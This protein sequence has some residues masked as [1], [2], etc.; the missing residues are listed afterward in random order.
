M[1][2]SSGSKKSKA[3]APL[4]GN[5]QQTLFQGS[6]LQDLAGAQSNGINPTDVVEKTPKKKQTLTV[7]ALT[8]LLKGIIQ[9]HPV[10]GHSVAVEGELS[11]VKQSSRGHLYFTLKDEHA[12]INCVLWGST[13]K[14][15]VFQP[16]DGQ[17]VFLT[18]KLDV[19]APGGSY[20]LVASHIEPVG[21]GSLQLAFEQTKA[22]LD[23]EGLFMSQFKKA[24]PEFPERVGIITAITGAV[25]HDM[26]RVIRRK[27]PLVSIL[28]H[29]VKVQGEGASQEITQAIETLNHPD[30]RLDAILLGRG[31]GSFE[32]LFCFS[33]EAVVRAVFNSRVPLITGIG[34]EPDF[35]LADAAADYSASTPTA[36]AEACIPDVLAIENWLESQQ[37]Q[38]LLGLQ[39]GLTDGEQTL[40]RHAT[41]L[42]QSVEMLA[43]QFEAKLER[44]TEMLESSH[45]LYFQAKSQ[46]LSTLSAELNAFNPLATLERGYAVVSLETTGSQTPVTTINQ[47]AI[48]DTV[49]IRVSDGVLLSC[50]QQKYPQTEF[51]PS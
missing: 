23:A 42:I 17:S 25:I 12:S 51:E 48:G 19:Y 6:G 3:T 39:N 47:V 10:L 43:H 22:R 33:E 34:H 21:I 31:G 41:Q 8:Q 13:A 36:A 5:G 2:K 15:L 20:S 28:I 7:Y 49:S 16:E 32:D 37:Q 11:N 45:S 35:S 9:D 18:G 1:P 44:L 24:I 30:Y 14:K 4:A 40:D 26:L 29:P 27:N 38:L 46:R 50:I